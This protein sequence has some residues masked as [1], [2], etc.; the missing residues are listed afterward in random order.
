MM[1]QIINW[2]TIVG[3]SQFHKQLNRSL[4]GHGLFKKN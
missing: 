2:T 4:L 1:I 3:K